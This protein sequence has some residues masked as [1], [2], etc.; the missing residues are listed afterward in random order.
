MTAVELMRILTQH[1]DATV[2]ISTELPPK[3]G[4]KQRMDEHIAAVAWDENTKEFLLFTESALLE[5]HD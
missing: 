2:V 4:N 3:D 5:K 1:P